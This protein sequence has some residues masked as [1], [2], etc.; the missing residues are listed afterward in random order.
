MKTTLSIGGMH[1]ASC[2]N[3]I[4]RA[5]KKADGVT[6]A[7]VNY[8]TE[9][10]TVTH[11]SEI[12]KTSDLI[13]AV[14]S[15]G[16]T[17]TLLDDDSEKTD[18]HE[19]KIIREK[20]ELEHLKKLFYISLI[21]SVPAFIIGM[22][23][24]EDGLF[25]AG[26][27]IPRAMFLLFVLATPVQFI[28]GARFYKGAW[29]ALKNKT[30]NMDTLIALG[31]TAAYFYSVYVLFFAAEKT[32]QYFEAATTIIT[33]LIMGKMLELIA[34]G[35]TSEAIKKLIGLAPKTATVKRNKKEIKIPI[36]DVVIGDI[37]IVKPG[38]KIPVDGIIIDG[39][40]SVDESM[41]TGE[42]MPIHKSV[43]NA[44]I[45]GT[46][47]KHGSFKFKA[48]KVGANT[49]LA[50]II[51]LIEEAQGKKAPIQKYADVISSY[52]VPV[53]LLIAVLTFFYW[54]YF[55]SEGVS[56]GIVA[57]VSVLVIACPCALGLATPTS[58]M[59]GTGLGARYGILIKGGDSLETAHKLNHVVF[60]KTGTITKGEPNVTDIISFSKITKK[61]LL[62]IAASIE[63]KSEHPLAQAIT[64]YSKKTNIKLKK[65]SKFTAIP[66]YGVKAKLG[67]T[68]YYFGNEKLMASKGISTK[69]ARNE[70]NKLE[71]D[72]KT[73]MMLSDS[74]KIAGIIAVA[75]VIKETS[76][77]AISD[78]KNIGIKVYM[79][80]GDNKRTAN[81]IAKQ[82]G[83]T[84]VFSEVLPEDKAKYIVGL[85]KSGK[86]AMA[87]DG[88]NDSPALAQAD[89]GIAM[90]SGT[91]VA[92]ES[93]NIVLMRNDLR[94]VSK[95]IKL[96]RLT[97]K[98]IKQNLF[99]AF[100]Y[101]VLGVPIAAGVFYY[102]T[103]W[104]LSPVIAGGAMAMSSVSVVTNSLLL[105]TKKL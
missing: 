26:I 68:I 59:V 100:V 62:Q 90:G 13:E 6:E 83:I 3:V 29:N 34:K 18:A 86:V 70:V 82:A 54:S 44:V 21:F 35:K 46:I 1:C 92:M 48:N 98:K 40:S 24:M 25:Y 9:Q 81:A 19:L 43:K 47:N 31:T 10:V 49:T 51:K 16:Y 104:L 65:I 41:I 33:L 88:I 74:K 60:D 8:S 95:A 32:G 96:S 38:E 37:I 71:T 45:G 57:A 22:F 105:K 30:S 64:E 61:E 79:I 63:Q 101:N 80:T 73:V 14:K 53:I 15:K 97:M 66:G 58:I 5:L 36:D 56:F 77:E 42:S 94:D 67:K 2:A 23:F 28:V 76:A 87:G 93:G 52:F 11:D 103:G 91:D 99:W 84:N 4:S 69:K 89:I 12:T 78:L 7:N 75:D 39:S 20:K 85:Q 17:A 27:E 102:W 72:G 55:S 50:R